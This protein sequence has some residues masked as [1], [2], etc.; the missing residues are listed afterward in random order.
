MR[1]VSQLRHCCPRPKQLTGASQDPHCIN[2]LQASCAFAPRSSQSVPEAAKPLSRKQACGSAPLSLR[3]QYGSYQQVLVF[4]P[5]VRRGTHSSRCRHWSTSGLARRSSHGRGRHGPAGPHGGVST[6]QRRPAHPDRPARGREEPL[7]PSR[8]CRRHGAL[9]RQ[10][11]G[12]LCVPGLLPSRL[13]VR[14]GV[15][16]G[17]CGRSTAVMCA[18]AMVLL[19]LPDYQR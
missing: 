10:S 13:A 12:R 2:T 4:Q 16:H 9:P 3:A 11:R 17:E 18:H 5:P 14:E 15:R 7:R 8:N 1:Q 6:T 19:L